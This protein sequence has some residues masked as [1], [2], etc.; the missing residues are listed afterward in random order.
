[1]EQQAEKISFV[2]VVS[3]ERRIEKLFHFLKHELFYYH[4]VIFSI[5]IKNIFLL[6]RVFP[7][8]SATQTEKEK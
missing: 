2:S 4:E 6:F 1:M 7:A 8:V 5:F 3:C